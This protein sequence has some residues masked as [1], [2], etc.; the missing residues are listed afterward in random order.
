MERDTTRYH[1]SAEKLDED[2]RKIPQC[3]I[4]S[5]YGRLVLLV[6]LLCLA[7]LRE[8]VL[9]LRMNRRVDVRTHL[10]DSGDTVRA[11]GSR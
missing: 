11:E 6:L 8:T 7:S 2:G 9:I 3:F 4:F 10:L 5:F 1:K